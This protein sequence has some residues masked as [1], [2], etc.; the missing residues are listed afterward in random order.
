MMR[1]IFMAVFIVSGLFNI[2]PAT[3]GE[4]KA[5]SYQ[6]CHKEAL[7]GD[8]KAQYNLGVMY[9][10]GRGISQD[11]KEAM[12]WYRKAANQGF[13]LAQYNLGDMYVHGHGTS[14][15]Y[16]EAMKWY[17]KAANQGLAQ[18][19]YN[20]GVMYARGQ[21]VIQDYNEA[22]KWYRKAANQGHV[23]A[24]KNL[25]LLVVMST[26]K[27][28]EQQA[29]QGHTKRN[30]P[31]AEYSLQQRRL[32]PHA[33]KLFG[34]PLVG[35]QRDELRTALKKAGVRALREKY[36]YWADKYIPSVALNGADVL[37]VEY[38]Q[39]SDRNGSGST[40]YFAKAQYRFPSS[41][42]LGQVARIRDMV[43]SKYGVPDQ[44]SGNLNLGNASFTW[45]KD[46]V[47]IKVWRGWPDTTT[48]L[49]YIVPKVNKAMEEEIAVNDRR[50]KQKKFKAQ[51]NAF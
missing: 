22:K 20:L 30:S 28:T 15:D 12:K 25:M 3:A 26:L 48:Y 24:Q 37:Y 43:A 34:V 29:N 36:S 10:G 1:V 49:E 51:S 35:A 27:Q 13:A 32:H 40:D 50:E 7:A 18:A 5:G 2:L 14:Q 11:Y 16:K 6:T 39:E 21:G 42:D 19:Q 8:D 23:Q 44:S 17:R 33:P 9:E 41:M 4:C 47:D 46:G 31:F 38:S 45:H